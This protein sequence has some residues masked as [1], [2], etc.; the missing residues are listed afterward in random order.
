MGWLTGLFSRSE[1]GKAAGEP[2]E[3]EQREDPAAATGEATEAAS[4]EAAGEASAGEAAASA[5]AAGEAVAGE[6]AAAAGPS[7]QAVAAAPV[8]SEAIVAS[9]AGRRYSTEC[10]AISTADLNAAASSATEAADEAAVPAA[11]VPS[12]E[13]VAEAGSHPAATAFHLK[14]SVGTWLQPLFYKPC[15]VVATDKAAEWHEEEEQLA[16]PCAEVPS[17]PERE[18]PFHHKP[19]VGSWLQFR[20]LEW[21]AELE[22]ARKDAAATSREA[23]PAKVV[24]E[25]WQADFE[26]FA[27]RPAAEAKLADAPPEGVAPAAEGDPGRGE[28]AG[29]ADSSMPQKDAEEEDEEEEAAGPVFTRTRTALMPQIAPVERKAEL[30]GAPTPGDKMAQASMQREVAQEEAELRGADPKLTRM[31]SAVVSPQEAELCDAGAKMTRMRSAVVPPQE[32]AEAPMTRMRSAVP[33]GMGGL[34]GAPCRVQESLA[35]EGGE[36]EATRMPPLPGAAEEEEEVEASGAGL[37]GAPLIRTRGSLSLAT[38][39][40][41][42]AEPSA[43]AKVPCPAKSIGAASDVASSRSAAGELTS[44]KD[45]VTSRSATEG[46]SMKE[47]DLMVGAS[48]DQ[49]FGDDR[50]WKQVGREIANSNQAAPPQRAAVHTGTCRFKIQVP[51]PYPGVQYRKSKCLD[52]RHPRYAENGSTVVGRVEDNGEWLKVGDH[53]FLPMRVGAVCIMELVSSEVGEA[54]VAPHAP[55][56]KPS[57]QTPWRWWTCCSGERAGASGD[58]EVVVNQDEGAGGARGAPQTAGNSRG[59]SR[60]EMWLGGI[61]G[62]ASGGA[63]AHTAGPGPGTTGGAGRMGGGRGHGAVVGTA[64]G[65]G[66]LGPMGPSAAAAASTKPTVGGGRPPAQEAEA[67]DMADLPRPM[68]LPEAVSRNP[69]SNLDAANRHFSHP[70]NPFSDKPASASPS[71]TKRRTEARSACEDGRKADPIKDVFQA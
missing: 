71:P 17:P 49:F 39:V 15:S 57:V 13:P 30:H 41:G 62:P 69:L 38:A 3:A 61:P 5:A 18:V 31:R 9:M 20:L 51:K 10:Q 63:H 65:T 36:G 50:I 21:E 29:K 6:A 8:A 42:L 26:A 55:S 25:P 37:R 1:E 67:E 16:R 2:A 70:I 52:D 27:D 45:T 28:A 4:T 56:V 58:T 12:C 66:G 46:T 33:P 24:E 48:L 7:I 22:A 34:G 43:P 11:A 47:V 59:P 19:S 14:P 53:I 35:E 60:E 64:M 23:E 54:H 44:A 68:P 32:A 40:P